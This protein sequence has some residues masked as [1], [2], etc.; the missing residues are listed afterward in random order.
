MNCTLGILTTKLSHHLYKHNRRNSIH[1]RGGTMKLVKSENHNSEFL[2][3][4]LNFFLYFFFFLLFFWPFI[5]K[6]RVLWFHE[7]MWSLII[8]LYVS[9]SFICTFY[10]MRLNFCKNSQCGNLVTKLSPTQGK[11]D[12]VFAGTFQDS[13]FMWQTVLRI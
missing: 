12:S 3:W 6:V 2:V 1:R 10:L 7:K 5:K 9:N 4:N 8:F 13:R 11:I